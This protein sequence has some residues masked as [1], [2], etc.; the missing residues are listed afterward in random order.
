MEVANSTRGART[1]GA[2]EGLS[3]CRRDMERPNQSANSAEQDFDATAV[4][5]CLLLE[6]F[7][8]VGVVNRRTIRSWGFPQSLWESAFNRDRNSRPRS[9]S[10]HHSRRCQTLHVEC[11]GRGSRSRKRNFWRGRPL[12]SPSS[13]GIALARRSSNVRR[14]PLH[15]MP[16]SCATL[17][18]HLT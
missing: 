9:C 3:S 5:S 7:W 4:A 1:D 17:P 8:S 6:R 15:I 18:H 14:F 16:L 10:R 11:S 13:C 2:E 12:P